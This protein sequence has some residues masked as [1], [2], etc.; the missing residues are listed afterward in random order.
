MNDVAETK[1][2]MAGEHDTGCSIFVR[3]VL[4]KCAPKNWRQKTKIPPIEPPKKPYREYSQ[5]AE[6]G[7]ILAAKNVVQRKSLVLYQIFY[8]K[9]NKYSQLLSYRT[10]VGT[11][12]FKSQ[13][14]EKSGILYLNNRT[15]YKTYC[16]LFLRGTEILGVRY[17]R[18]FRYSPESGIRVIDCNSHVK[19]WWEG[20]FF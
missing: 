2:R 7:G 11:K 12:T 5:M 19:T 18:D 9:N 17:V 6:D 3:Q 4:W 13:V 20:V 1:R 15:M 16:E 10:A 8:L 14:Y